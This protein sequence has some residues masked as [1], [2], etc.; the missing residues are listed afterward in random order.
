[1]AQQLPKELRDFKLLKKKDIDVVISTSCSL[2]HVPYT[3]AN[4]TKLDEKY[5]KHFS[6]AIEKLGELQDLNN[7]FNAK[8]QDSHE[9][10]VKN[11]ALF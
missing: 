7:I 4:E 10:L 11:I 1:M 3:L 2:L 6:F 9:A 5:K 8:S